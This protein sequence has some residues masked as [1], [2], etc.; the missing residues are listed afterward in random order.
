MAAESQ[1]RFDLDPDDD[2][3]PGPSALLESSKELLALNRGE[4]EPDERDAAYFMR[5]YSPAKIMAE[6]VSLDSEKTIRNTMRMVNS[7]RNLSP[8]SANQFGSLV[9]RFITAHPLTMPLEEINPMGILEQNRRVTRMGPG[10]IASSDSVTEAASNVHPSVFGFLSAWETPESELAGVDSRMAYGVRRG[11]DGYLYQRFIDN[12]T[13][14]LVW[15]NA[16][17]LIGKNIAVGQKTKSQNAN[18]R[19]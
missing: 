9:E 11:S 8:I 10:G 3:R 18:H 7:R 5:I 12:K 16:K 14:S 6:R 1:F 2:F 4:R 15:L 13:G 17:D 19:N